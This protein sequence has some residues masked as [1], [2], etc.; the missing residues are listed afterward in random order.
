MLVIEKSFILLAAVILVL[1]HRVGLGFICMDQLAV[2]GFGSM[3]LGFAHCLGQAHST[4]SCVASKLQWSPTQDRW[5][6]HQIHCS[7][8]FDS[9]SIL[10]APR[11]DHVF[12][13]GLLTLAS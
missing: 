12:I 5:R 2:R 6:H 11:L 7:D 13:A 8:L 9:S 10:I 4:R 1:G 3:E